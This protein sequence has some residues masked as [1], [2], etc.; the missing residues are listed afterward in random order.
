MKLADVSIRRPVL[1]VVM[2]ASLMVTL[3]LKAT[4][5]GMGLPTPPGRTT[6]SWPA[7]LP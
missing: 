4:H 2:V 6:P 5:T 1:A 3:S 7:M